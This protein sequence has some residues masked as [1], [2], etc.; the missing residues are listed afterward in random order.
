MSVMAH[1]ADAPAGESSNGMDAGSGQ[2]DEWHAMEWWRDLAISVVAAIATRVR[3]EGIAR[4]DA[5]EAG[6]GWG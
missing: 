4:D 2:R 3:A 1:E 5:R 6:D